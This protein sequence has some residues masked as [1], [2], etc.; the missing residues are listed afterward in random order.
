[1][2]DDKNEVLIHFGV[3]THIRPK[4]IYVVYD[5]D[6]SVVFNCFIVPICCPELKFCIA[7]TSV[8]DHFSRT[9]SKQQNSA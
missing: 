5:L 6:G 1:L 3:K 4:W 7:L 2:E 9:L 8:I